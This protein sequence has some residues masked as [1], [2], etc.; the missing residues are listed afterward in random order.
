MELQD[1]MRTDKQPAGGHVENLAV[2]HIERSGTRIFERNYRVC[3][4]AI[5]HIALDRPSPAS[6][7]SAKSTP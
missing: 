6:K 3:S 5:G 1:N 2:A 4:G 7:S